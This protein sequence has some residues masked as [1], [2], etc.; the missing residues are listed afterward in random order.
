VAALVRLRRYWP[1]CVAACIGLAASFGAF[2]LVR[3]AARDRLAVELTRQ[4]ENRSRGLQEVLSR[5]QGTLEGFAASFPS[6]QLDRERFQAYS[7]SV[8]LASNMLRS[9]LRSL[10][11][12]PFVAQADRA[13]FEAAAQA[14]GLAGYRIIERTADGQFVTAAPRAEYLPLRYVEPV[15]PATPLGTDQLLNP[16]RDTAVRLALTKGTATATAPIAFRDGGSGVLIYV[17]VYGPTA[18][19]PATRSADDRP[20]GLLSFRL[21]I[22]PSIESIVQALEPLPQDLEMYVVDDGAPAGERII[23][24]HAA[25]PGD[26]ATAAAAAQPDAAQP[27]EAVALVEPIYG[28]S[29]AFAGR[30]WTVIV[31]PTGRYLSGALR[32]VGWNEL[33][34]GIVLTVLVVAHLANS[35]LRADRLRRHAEELRQ[36]VAVRKAAER[37]AAAASQA[38]SDFLAN[39]SHELRTPLNAIIGFSEVM[40]TEL[41]GRIGNPRYVQYATDIRESAI[42]LLTVISEVLDFSR[43]E[44]GGLTLHESP[45][46]IAAAIGSA[47]RL[48]E[49]R[50]A[51]GGIALETA[52]QPDVGGLRAD[53]R[54]VKQMLINL[55]SNAVKFTPEG[56]RISIRAERGGDELHLKVA[57][58]GVGMAP[59]EIPVALTAFRQVDSGWSRKHGGTGLGLPLVKSM[60][61]LHGGSLSIESKRGLGTTV[62]LTFPAAR[63]MAPAAFATAASPSAASR[64]MDAVE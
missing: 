13:A 11:W 60:I 12:A 51:S 61:E 46:D 59:E 48:V 10:G 19:Q 17:P 39:M 44:A 29:L 2:Y 9:G 37:A 52:L 53:E 3:H 32:D 8:F 58:T 34:L 49:G 18:A 36:E 20:V 27:D 56:G 57:D 64:T 41:F 5:Y 42:H 30:D 35:R 31:R 62:T 45:V 14:E 55:L 50:A 26:A 63:V 54:M 40:C 25:R 16:V 4:A 6:A 43:A 21:F 1:A 15:E 47:R 24:H 22:G 33:A 7:R 28:A 23:Y 38:K